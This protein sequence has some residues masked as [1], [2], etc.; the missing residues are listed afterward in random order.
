[1]NVLVIDVNNLKTKIRVKENGREGL[2]ILKI[3]VFFSK[4]T[5]AFKKEKNYGYR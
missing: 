1:M 2:T 4:R 5:I 3:P